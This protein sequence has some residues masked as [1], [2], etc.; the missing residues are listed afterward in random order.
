LTLSGSIIASPR[1]NTAPIATG[2]KFIDRFGRSKLG[3]TRRSTA[4]S[5]EKSLGRLS[6][7][8]GP[9]FPGVAEIAAA[10][11]D[12]PQSAKA[13]FG[14]EFRDDLQGS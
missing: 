4:L 12:D 10:Y 7:T 1:W 3:A 8:C 14:A 5:P 13:E 9:L 2:D 6:H 11:R